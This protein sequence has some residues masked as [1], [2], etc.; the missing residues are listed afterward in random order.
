MLVLFLVELVAFMSHSTETMVVLDPV[1][2]QLV[3]AA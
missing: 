1:N 2:D 3:R